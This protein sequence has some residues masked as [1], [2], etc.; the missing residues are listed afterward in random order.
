MKWKRLAL[1][2]PG[3]IEVSDHAFDRGEIVQRVGQT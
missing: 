3:A 2:L 1:E